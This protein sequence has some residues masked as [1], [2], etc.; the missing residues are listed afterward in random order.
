MINKIRYNEI[1]LLNTLG[2]IIKTLS[3][4][5]RGYCIK[6]FFKRSSGLVFIG[7]KVSLTE[8]N[9]IIVGKNVKFEDFSE[10]Q[11][12]SRL[13]LNFGDNV[14]IGRNTMIRPS[15]Y[16]GIDIG[17]GFSI[18][19][20]S[21]IGPMGYIGCAGFIEIGSNVMIG[22]RVSMFAENHN[23]NR[24]DI[25][26]KDQGVNNKGIIIKDNC[27]IGSGVVILD[28]VTI[29]SGSVIGAGTIVTKDIPENSIILDKRSKSIRERTV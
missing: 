17:A 26:I 22:P 13:G 6:I 27:W 16:Y 10:I 12:L 24:V 2:I 29:G 18:G 21:S 20:N 23:F 7:N 9:R 28:G 3:K 14:T 5:V 11:G 25:S 8:K 1:G 15:S 4:L 19:N